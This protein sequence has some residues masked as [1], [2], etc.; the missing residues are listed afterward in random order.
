MFGSSG[1]CGAGGFWVAHG[2]LGP[3]T[4]MSAR[5]RSIRWARL[6]RTGK[7]NS[8]GVSSTKV[9][10]TWPATNVGWAS[11][12]WRNGMLVFTPRTRNSASARWSF[13]TAPE[14]VW[15]RAVT[16]TSSES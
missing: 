9:V 2:V 5:K 4:A 16:L 12:R 8:S 13:W 3:L 14:K 7:W 10:V 6:R 11:T 15:E 1:S